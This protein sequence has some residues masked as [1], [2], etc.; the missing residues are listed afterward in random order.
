MPEINAIERIWDD[1]QPFVREF[2]S[3][4]C[5]NWDNA[6]LESG[7]E[8]NCLQVMITM[9]VFYENEKKINQNI[10]LLFSELQW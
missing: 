1:R 9:D 4:E 10:P 7:R 8:T 6:C 2:F 5:G 3:C